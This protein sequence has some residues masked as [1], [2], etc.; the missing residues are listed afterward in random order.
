LGEDGTYG[1]LSLG[2]TS[3]LL[4]LLTSEDAG[5]QAWADAL[6]EFEEKYGIEIAD[7]D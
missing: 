5:T 3:E 4:A 7:F 6:T 2:Q 1:D